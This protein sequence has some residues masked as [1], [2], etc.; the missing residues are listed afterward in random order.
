MQVENLEIHIESIDTKVQLGDQF[1][2]GL[3]VD[4]FRIA[5]KCLMGW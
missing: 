5:R 3:P 4:S 2:K 1:R